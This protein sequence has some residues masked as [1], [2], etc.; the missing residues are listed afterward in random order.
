MDGDISVTRGGIT[1]PLRTQAVTYFIDLPPHLAEN[2]VR[3]IPEALGRFRAAHP[4]PTTDRAPASREPAQSAL[5]VTQ[6]G[7]RVR[8]TVHEHNGRKHRVNMTRAD[9]RDLAQALQLAAEPDAA[10]K[11]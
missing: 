10:K 3:L 7:E 11:H 1:V 2:L 4:G 9:A 6:E 5:E 8:L